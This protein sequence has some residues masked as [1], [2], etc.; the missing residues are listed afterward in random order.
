MVCTMLISSW[1]YESR[2]PG[3]WENAEAKENSKVANP[4]IYMRSFNVTFPICPL[5][6]VPRPIDNVNRRF[7]DLKAICLCG[8]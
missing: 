7:S 4:H 8:S 5:E 1:I 2:I 6:L 3:V